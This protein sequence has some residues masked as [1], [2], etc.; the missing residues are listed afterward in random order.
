MF[1]ADQLREASEHHRGGDGQRNDRHRQREQQWDKGQ[2]GRD[3]IAERRVKPHARRDHHHEK[4]QG[5]WKPGNGVRR[6][7]PPQAPTVAKKA[8]LNNGSITRSRG[9]R[10]TSA[11]RSVSASSSC[12]S[13]LGCRA[14]TSVIDTTRPMRE[15][16][17]ADS[18]GHMSRKRASVFRSARFVPK[19]GANQNGKGQTR[20]ELGTQ[21]QRSHPGEIA[22]LPLPRKVHTNAAAHFQP[23]RVFAWRQQHSR[24]RRRRFGGGAGGR[25]HPP[26]CERGSCPAPCAADEHAVPCAADEHAVPGAAD[27]H[28][29]PGAADE[30]A[31]PCA[32]DEHA[33]PGAADEARSSVRRG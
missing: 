14:I 17:V 22:R 11:W 31:V 12:S 7:D 32:A 18:L 16:R 2:L 5:R 15:P 25:W 4:T 1:A 29:V 24:R 26:P 19:S 33:V 28:A 6:V 3:R 30:H 10:P 27:E 13:R 21:S 8:T 9:V 20:R 23:P